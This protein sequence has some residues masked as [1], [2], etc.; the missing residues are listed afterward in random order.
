MSR[1]GMQVGK[2]A[3]PLFK[4]LP[5]E[6]GYPLLGE[7]PAHQAQHPLLLIVTAPKSAVMSQIGCYRGIQASESVEG[8]HGAPSSSEPAWEPAMRPRAACRCPGEDTG[9]CWRG[10]DVPAGRRWS[11]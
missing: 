1:V 2:R 3:S 4:A 8:V 10:C 9:M 6:I 7:R 5:I 11:S